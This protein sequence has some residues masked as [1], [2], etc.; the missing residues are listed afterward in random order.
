[1][2]ISSTQDTGWQRLY[3]YASTAERHTAA[4]AQHYYND[5]FA[6]LSPQPKVI[7]LSSGIA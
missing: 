4:Y 7:R 2:A 1:M 6:D 3:K 5:L